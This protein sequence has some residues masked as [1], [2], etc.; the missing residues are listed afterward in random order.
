VRFR[1]LIGRYQDLEKQNFKAGDVVETEADLIAMFGRDKFARLTD[2]P[3][4]DGEFKATPRATY[5]QEAQTARH[6]VLRG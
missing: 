2:N 1:L 6:S 4:E 3:A 5:S